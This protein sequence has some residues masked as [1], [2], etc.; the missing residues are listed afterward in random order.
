M[1]FDADQVPGTLSVRC[2]RAGDRFTPF[3]SGERRLKTFL[4][5]AK[6]PRWE[7]DRVPIVEAAGAIL[8]VGGLRRGAPAPVT[9]ATRRVLELALNPPARPR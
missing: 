2:R 8:W 1:A 9:V 3:G 6:V 7:R 5:D 4:I